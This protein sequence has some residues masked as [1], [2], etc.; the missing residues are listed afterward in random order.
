M[1]CKNC[2]APLI[3]VW[4]KEFFLCEYCKTLHFPD[5]NKDN[6]RSLE[7]PTKI[8]CPICD[9]P[10]VEALLDQTHVLHCTDCKGI[11]VDTFS[12]FPTILFIRGRSEGPELPPKPLSESELKREIFCPKC[13]QKMDTHPYAGPGN[14][15]IDTCN[16]C[17]LNWL[18]YGEFYQIVNASGR[19]QKI[20]FW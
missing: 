17:A 1:N 8:N 18:D 15:V 12:F 5:A 3:L 6:I 16:H 11:L 9:K 14:I 19:Y 13:N 4:E 10:L 2:G 20:W 7:K